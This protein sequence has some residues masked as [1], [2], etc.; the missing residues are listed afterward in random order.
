[1]GNFIA[2]FRLAR[3]ASY[4]Q[5]CLMHA[6]FAKVF[7]IVSSLINCAHNCICLSIQCLILNAVVRVMKLQV[8]GYL[9]T[10]IIFLESSDIAFPYY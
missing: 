5:A 3:K 8:Y 7:D 6:H 4:I 9:F 2:F 10:R 1:M